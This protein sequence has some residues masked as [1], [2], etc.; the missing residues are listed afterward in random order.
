[1]TDI[2]APKNPTSVPLVRWATMQSARPSGRCIANAIVND[3]HG[4][5]PAVTFGNDAGSSPVNR[6]AC[7]RHPAASVF[8]GD[9]L[10]GRSGR[11]RFASALPSP[12]SSNE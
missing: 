5:S 8:A 1:M 4:R 9:V 11:A 12:I 10:P 2:S 6:S 7:P 3:S